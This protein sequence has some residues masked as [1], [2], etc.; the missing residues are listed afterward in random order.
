M[1]VASYKQNRSTAVG[2]FCR[3]QGQVLRLESEGNMVFK[4]INE[5]NHLSKIR[6]AKKNRKWAT[7]NHGERKIK[8]E[9]VLKNNHLLHEWL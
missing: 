9:Q 3:P 5:I 4:T 8:F 6:Q 1:L 2:R 7:G